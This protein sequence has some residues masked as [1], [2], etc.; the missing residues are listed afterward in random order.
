MANIL[1]VFSFGP[2]PGLDLTPLMFTIS[3]LIVAFGIVRYRLF[4]L[5]PVACSRIF[6]TMSDGVLVTDRESIVIEINPAA[7]RILRVPVKAALVRPVEEILPGTGRLIAACSSANEPVHDEIIIR[8]GESVEYYDAAC[9]PLDPI[10]EEGVGHLLI[11]RNITERKR[12]E[13][14]LDEANKKLN[15]LASI[16][17]HDILN[18]ITALNCYLDL[19]A[20]IAGSSEEE[21]CIEKEKQIIAVIQEQIGF[22]REYQNL[23]VELPL[24]QNLRD[25]LSRA[26][27]QLDL[28][29][30][31]LEIRVGQYEV[32]ADP[33]LE[34][35]FYNLLDNSLRYGETLTAITIATEKR[36]DDLVVSCSDDGIG[37]STEDK[38]KLFTKGFGRHT[39]LGLFLS[40]EILAITGISITE[41]GVP[42]NGARFEIR[43]PAG[44]Y[45]QSDIKKPAR[46]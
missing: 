10:T 43:V 38:K 12:A 16:T 34:R 24:W 27:P 15:L 25:T 22:T 11:L 23:G 19:N 42:G 36:G 9:S 7:E 40:K 30:I 3:G 6:R 31:R 2:V 33:M 41:T 45:R 1:Y 26:V 17:R 8:S 21:A 46:K 39:G 37:I 35:V 18:Q 20:G 13:M 5:M 28:R 32:Y 29:S 4:S 14:A 44:S